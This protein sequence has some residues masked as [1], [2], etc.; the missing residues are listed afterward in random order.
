[1]ATA[2]QQTIH[3]KEA[4]TMDCSSEGVVAEVDGTW[5]FSKYRGI[6]IT[7]YNLSIGCLLCF[8]MQIEIKS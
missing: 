6:K 8:S 2:T 7:Y 5:T 3:R 4:K 1:M